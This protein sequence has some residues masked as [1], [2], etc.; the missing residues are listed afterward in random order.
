MSAPVSAGRRF[1]GT[2]VLFGITPDV[3]WADDS[4]TMLD[5]GVT[6][7]VVSEVDLAHNPGGLVAS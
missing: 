2:H 7:S 6:L 3:G 5:P 1:E 4:W